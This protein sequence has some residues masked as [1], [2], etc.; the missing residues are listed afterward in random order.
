MCFLSIRGATLRSTK[1]TSCWKTD[2]FRTI[3][4]KLLYRFFLKYLHRKDHCR[5]YYEPQ[6][7][8][9]QKNHF[10]LYHATIWFCHFGLWDLFVPIVWKVRN[11][12]SLDTSIVKYIVRLWYALQEPYWDIHSTSNK[13]KEWLLFHANKICI[14]FERKLTAFTRSTGSF[15]RVFVSYNIFYIVTKAHM[16]K[17]GVCA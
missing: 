13:R 10:S 7:E 4:N 11:R 14:R 8:L 15:P 12:F 17:R 3:I 5:L 16:T 6:G 2:R 1:S 9:L